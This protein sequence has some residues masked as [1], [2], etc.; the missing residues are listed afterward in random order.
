MT[1]I[2][3]IHTGEYIVGLHIETDLSN[4]NGI[5]K[6][7]NVWVLSKKYWSWPSE[8]NLNDKFW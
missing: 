1:P 7:V 2:F 6:N 4:H 5:K 8:K 3:T